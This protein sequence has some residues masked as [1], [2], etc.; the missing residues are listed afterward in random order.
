[1]LLD[2]ATRIEWRAV[3]PWPRLEAGEIHLW[4]AGLD[5]D[6]KSRQRFAASLSARERERATRLRMA[7]HR[8]RYIA[9]RGTAR[10]LL[11]HYLDRPPSTIRFELGPYGKPAVPNRVAGKQLCFNYTDSQDMALYA[12]AY[13]CELGV[14][15]EGLARKI[16]YERIAL[17]KFSDRES[18]ALLEFSDSQGKQAFLAC[19]TRKEAYGKAKGFGICYPLDS[20]DLCTDCTTPFMT[21]TD[22]ALPDGGEYWTL[23]QFYPNDNFVAAIVYAGDARRL[24]YF[25]Y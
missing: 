17:R 22:G 8:H 15:L 6:E 25:D 11:S 9:G 24:R 20:V 18:K 14:D 7:R 12:F 21:I 4:R 10:E 3:R 19:W 1:M 5:V 16:E 13:D 23:Q 2:V